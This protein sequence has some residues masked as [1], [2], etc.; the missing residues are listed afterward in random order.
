MKH[1][2]LLLPLFAMSTMTALAD[3]IQFTHAD[4]RV[5]FV[6]KNHAFRIQSTTDGGATYSPVVTNCIPE[7]SYRVAS[8]DVRTLS[9]ATL[10]DVSY[11]TTPLSD[12]QFGAGTCHTF[13]FSA[14]DEAV[15]LVERFYA[16]DDCPFLLVDLTVSSES[17]ISS[18]Y[19]APISTSTSYRYLTA[20]QNNRMLKVP[21]DNDGFTRYHRYKM[22]TS[23][24]SYEV[25]AIYSGDDRHGVV[26]GSID[27]NHWKSAIDVKGESNSNI[28]RL[29]A[30]SG[31]SDSET[32]DVLPHG[33]VKGTT[34]S[35]ARFI[36]DAVSDWRDGM[37]RFAWA[38]TRVA[39]K[40]ET[41]TDG[42][43]M[44]WQSWGVLA[45][46]SN[47]TDVSEIAQ[48]YADVLQPGGFCN[49]QG[50]VILSL[51]ASD[52]LNDNQRKE[53]CTLGA[54]R[55]Q[56]VGCYS[57]P[58][59]LWWDEASLDRYTATIGGKT[60]HYRDAVLKVKG[61]SYKFD[62]AYALDP[63]H[64]ITK[65]SIV[66]F[67][68]SAAAKGVR[69][70]KCDFVNAGIVQA[71]SY[72]KEGITT[73]VEA[74]NEGMRYL[75]DRA[76]A[77]G[78]FVALSIAPLFPYQYAN[79]RRVACDTWGAIGHSEY[80][81]NAMSG[82]WW[83]SGLYQYNDPDHIV[84]IGTNEQLY[85][86]EGENRARFTTG[87]VTGMTLVADNF[88]TT[89]VSKRG[90]PGLSKSRAEKVMLNADVNAI[91]RL[92]VSFRPLYG[93]KE[94]QSREDH[95]ENFHIYRTN[96]YLYVAGINYG[97]LLPLKG[98]ISLLDLGLTLEECG[99]VKELWTGTLL[100][101]TSSLLPYDIPAKDARIYR[102]SLKTENP[103][104][105]TPP[106]AIDNA[107]SANGPS[108]D[109]QGR[110][111]PE[112]QS[113]TSTSRRGIKI[114]GKRKTVIL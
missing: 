88:S 66:D 104:G 67:V 64:P 62:G 28:A 74:Y 30:Y 14:A 91:A 73:A 37:E 53:L 41:W 12:E 2:T 5:T 43:P 105:V 18:N 108:Y 11:T 9:V 48:Y 71:D 107:P 98:S 65:Q 103:D 95:A 40:C 1:T 44:G 31:A 77:K 45:E 78:I 68:N 32:R 79:S 46:K 101:L 85:N 57:T 19:L 33:Y 63:T 10:T 55:N 7:A 60:Y 23:M 97:S 83:T 81:M 38:N 29:R 16:Y 3:D 15:H 96:E 36:L 42:T 54:A 26:I 114:T 70:I 93:C 17:A 75:A 34:V 52:G 21:F 24:T 22:N 56:V 111:Y 110:A 13:T 99:D 109:L 92:G 90:N 25:T 89:N 84:L 51:D 20:S 59:S 94:D 27:H 4:W 39:P 112:Q 35:S 87:C 82:G 80:A 69:Y 106:T 102:I 61:E 58:F 113:K 8:S 50:K 47:Y 6:E 86:S 100:P 72:Y 76:R 49:D